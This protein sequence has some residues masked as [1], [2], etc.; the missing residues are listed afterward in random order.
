MTGDS[1]PSGVSFTATLELAP[2]ALREAKAV[3]AAP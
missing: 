1:L 3:E 2:L